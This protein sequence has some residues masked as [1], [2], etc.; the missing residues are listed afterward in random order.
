[1]QVTIDWILVILGVI[2]GMVLMFALFQILQNHWKDRVKI[3]YKTR[4]GVARFMKL[5]L[6]FEHFVLHRDKGYFL[7]PY[8]SFQTPSFAM[9][10]STETTYFIH[11]DSVFPFYTDPIEMPFGMSQNDYRTR[12]LK[13]D[14]KIK[15]P[16]QYNE[17]NEQIKPAQELSL[18]ILAQVHPAIKYDPQRVYATVKTTSQSEVRRESTKNQASKWLGEFQTWVKLLIVIGILGLVVGI[19][20]IMVTLGGDTEVVQNT[21]QTVQD[22]GGRLVNPN[23]I[24]A[25]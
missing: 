17:K 23:Q 3:L 18:P 7:D 13:G 1:M 22:Q 20:N 6:F 14:H 11:E 12:F 5:K 15:I 10:G 2:I 25:P 24:N 9:P 21:V 8:F 4:D 16:A 19:A